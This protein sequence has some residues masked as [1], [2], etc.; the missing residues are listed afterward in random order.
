MENKKW[1]V[2]MHKTPS[3][4]VYIGITSEENI[5]RRWKNGYGYK[6]QLFYLAIEK[7]GWNNIRH[8][9]IAENLTREKALLMEQKLIEKYKSNDPKYGY[10][11]TKGGEYPTERTKV[12]K[13]KISNSLK[14]YYASSEGILQK[15]KIKKQK[16]EYYKTHDANFKGCNHT[17][18]TKKIMSE[19][20]K[21]R[22][23]NRSQK[24]LML[25]DNKN[26]IKEFESK[27]QAL[28]FLNIVCYTSLNKAIKE[29]RKY[30][31]Y[32]WK[33]EQTNEISINKTCQ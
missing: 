7:Y 28:N 16:K 14:N 33:E 22:K 3:E 11:Q 6:G 26:I 25:D 8:I 27:K 9:I 31:N 30:K 29:K 10:N 18:E 2:Y 32:Y 4:K 5:N 21:N 19:K 17:K 12:I 1:K 20:A 13:D 23:P 24:I 15:E